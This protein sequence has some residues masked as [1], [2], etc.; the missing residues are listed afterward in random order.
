MCLGNGGYDISDAV[1]SQD[2]RGAE[3]LE[4]KLYRRREASRQEMQI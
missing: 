3:I 4:M 2:G 1:N